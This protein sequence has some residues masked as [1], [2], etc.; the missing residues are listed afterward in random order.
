LLL[1]T[2]TERVTLADLDRVRRSKAPKGE[3]KE[4]PATGSTQAQARPKSFQKAGGAP[5]NA[6]GS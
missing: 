3:T 6:A 4:R 5:K 1:R 2:G